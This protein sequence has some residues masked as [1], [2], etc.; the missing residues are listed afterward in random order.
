MWPISSARESV[1]VSV[2]L[3]KAEEKAPAPE[4]W[5]VDLG[6]AFHNTTGQMASLSVV[7]EESFYST[8]H[9]TR[10]T[11][12][13]GMGVFSIRGQ[14]CAPQEEPVVMCSCSCVIL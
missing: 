6:M 3:G 12:G 2:T 5:S 9:P 7:G 8:P 11:G 1:K 10:G 13:I 4:P 14:V